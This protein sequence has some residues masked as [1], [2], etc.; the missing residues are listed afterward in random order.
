[1]NNEIT[2]FLS[3]LVQTSYF[4]YFKINLDKQCKFWNAQHF[5]A[6]ENCAV[7]ILDDFDWAQVTNESL[8]P[9]KLGELSLPDSTS[10]DNSIETEEVQTCEDLDYSEIDDDHNCVYVN[11]L[12]NPERFTGYGGN[13][14]FDV[15]K[16]I[17]LEN[18]FPN[19]NPMS[20]STDTLHGEEVEQCIEKKIFFRLV[21]G[22]HASIAVHLSSEYLNSETGEFYPNLRVFMERVGMFNDRLSNIYFN[23]ALVSQA[24]VKLNEIL[25]LKEFIQLGYDDITPA[26][27]EHLIAN[28][29]VEDVEV[30]D[31][32]LL[33]DIIPSLEANVIFNTTNLFDDDN[34]KE[35][36]RSRFRNVSAI[37]DCVGC[38]RCRM[39]GKI[40]T[41]G[42][43]TALKILFEDDNLDNHNLK[44]RRIEIVALVNTLDRLSKSIIHINEFK[45]RYL[46]HLQDVAEGRA[47][48]GVY[49]KIQENNNAGSFAF[50]FVSQLPQKKAAPPQPPKSE[51][52]K[53]EKKKEEQP[54]RTGT[55]LTA[56]EIG[57]LKPSQRTFAQEFKLAF[58]EVWEALKF[59]LSSY[60]QFPALL[61]KITL[62]QLNQWWGQLIGKP[63]TV[64]YQSPIDVQAREY[65]E[66][67]H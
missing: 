21:S 46:Q 10:V 42:Y 13:Q 9:S 12:N 36:F 43:G 37:M 45:T 62:V 3:E 66:L 22:L 15:W 60:K 7:E 1:L 2:P 67:I 14:S 48:P 34:L 20:M 18:C 41:I 6:T 50:P 17:Y 63:V 16:A 56:E 30:Y 54:K 25:P 40:Q 23:Y 59:V 31:K 58:V 19:T 5:C 33:Q 27:K 52:P 53:V 65:S 29:D 24:L 57:K 47:Q 49:D 26:Q 51:P 8:K 32:L 39:W 28:H 4:R 38:D 35:E 44:F 11:L 55:Q 61:G 64:E